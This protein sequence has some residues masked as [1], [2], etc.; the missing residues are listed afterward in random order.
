MKASELIAKLQQLVD[1]FG[2]LEVIDD[3]S[4][5]GVDDVFYRYDHEEPDTE[6]PV[7]GLCL[8]E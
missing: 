6:F 3:E 2:D 8:N 1:E 4:L 5:S 7:F